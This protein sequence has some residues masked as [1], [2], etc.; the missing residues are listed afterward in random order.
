MAVAALVSLYLQL[1]LKWN[2]DEPRDFAYIMLV[3]VTLTTIAWLATT[4]LTPAESS[5]TLHTFYRRVRPH[6]PGWNIRS[7]MPRRRVSAI[8]TVAAD[9]SPTPGLA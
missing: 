6:G 4:W 7:S 9:G 3:T 8:G 1:G 5:E 2:G